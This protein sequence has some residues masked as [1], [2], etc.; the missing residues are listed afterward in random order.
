[1]NGELLPILTL[2]QNAESRCMQSLVAPRLGKTPGNSILYPPD[3]WAGDSCVSEF[4][5]NLMGQGNF[6]ASAL[7]ASPSVETLESHFISKEIVA[8]FQSGLVQEALL[9]R[10]KEIAEAEGEFV[11]SLGLRYQYSG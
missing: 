11:K 3:K 4:R 2:L 1:M 6:L 9:L 10:A 8:A 7:G 5:E